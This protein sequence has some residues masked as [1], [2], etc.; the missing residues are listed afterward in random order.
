ME[1][2][3]PITRY[4]VSYIGLQDEIMREENIYD[5][6]FTAIGLQP[7]A[8]YNF[9]VVGFVNNITEPSPPATVV[10]NTSVPQGRNLL[11]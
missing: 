6:S 8:S 11:T 2:N 3:G 9:T 7:R 5:L 1:R 10:A 4:L